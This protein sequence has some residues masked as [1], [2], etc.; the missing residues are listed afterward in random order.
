MKHKLNLAEWEKRKKAR[1]ELQKKK[2]LEEKAK[3]IDTSRSITVP[4]LK[5]LLQWKLSEEEYKTFASGKR[6]A[7]LQVLWQQF[8]DRE[9]S[10]IVLP[11]EELEPPPLPLIEDTDLGK[12]CT[13]LCRA[14]VAATTKM[15]AEDVRKIA[16]ELLKTCEERGI[17]IYEA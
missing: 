11:P 8:K 14:T 17:N 2:E 16:S 15:S 9:V 12:S 4:N 13:D 10:N 6:S 3:S 5:I 7:E 1:C